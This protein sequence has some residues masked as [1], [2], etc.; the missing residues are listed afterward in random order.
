[1]GGGGEPG[2]GAKAVLKWF[3]VWICGGSGVLDGTWGSLRV[4][5]RNSGSPGALWGT[6]MGPEGSSRVLKGVY[7]GPEVSPRGPWW[8][9]EVLD[10]T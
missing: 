6:W 5:K 9:L 1:M 8:S 10:G 4:L 3:C 7:G 2:G